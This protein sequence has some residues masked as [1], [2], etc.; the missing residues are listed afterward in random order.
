M[1][2]QTHKK[3]EQMIIININDTWQ[4]TGKRKQGARTNGRVENKI[5]VMDVQKDYIW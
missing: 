1:I 5:L 4:N 2:E 3:S